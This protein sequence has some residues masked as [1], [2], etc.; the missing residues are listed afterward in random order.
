MFHLLTD[1]FK[2]FICQNILMYESLLVKTVNF[3]CFRNYFIT[4]DNLFGYFL[5]E[6]DPDILCFVLHS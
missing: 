2:Q 4:D 6:C 3:S 5:F 1:L